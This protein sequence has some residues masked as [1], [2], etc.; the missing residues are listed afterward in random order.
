MSQIFSKE[1]YSF[2]SYEESD[3]FHNSNDDWPGTKWQDRLYVQTELWNRDPVDQV[4]YRFLSL[5]SFKHC[6]VFFFNYN[7]GLVQIDKV[8]LY[9]NW[10][11]LIEIDGDQLFI[12]MQNRLGFISIEKTES[13]FVGREDEGLTWLYEV[14]I[15][16]HT[17]KLDIIGT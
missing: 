17:L 1:S 6:I 13:Y 14:T 7:F 4:L 16:S 12:Y 3:K 15:S 8:L 10:P 11:S 2:L 5:D 9:K